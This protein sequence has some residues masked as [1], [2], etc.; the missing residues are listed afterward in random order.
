MV[1]LD[2]GL[3]LRQLAATPVLSDLAAVL[4][5]G[6]AAPPLRGC[7]T[8]V[9]AG[10]GPG[11]PLCASVRGRNAVNF[12]V[13]ADGLR[14]SAWPCSPSSCPA[15]TSRATARPT[16]PRSKTWRAGRTRRSRPT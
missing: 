16:S 12:R 13:L 2:R 11:G 4:A 5:G 10:R 14:A 15:T 1:K 3:S 8:G 9:G 7:C 6:D